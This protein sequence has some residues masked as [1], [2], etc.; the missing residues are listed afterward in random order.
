[1]RVAAVFG[2][3]Q[4]VSHG[5]GLFLFAA[6][7]PLMRE[8]IAITNW[9]LAAIGALTQLSYLAGALLLGFIG[10]KV[11]SARLVLTTGTI[12]TILLF[13]M[14]QLQDPIII[15]LVL[16][17]LAASAAI[18]WGAIVE[19]VGRNS[20]PEKC[21]TYLSFA[22]SGTAWGYGLNGLLILLVV[23]A[24]GWQSSWQIAALVGLIVVGLTWRLLTK[25]NSQSST[26]NIP[27]QA[28]IPASKLLTTII[29]ERTA[30][31]ACTVCFLV[32]FSTMPF[33]NWLN[34]YLHELQLPASVGGYTWTIVG[35]TGMVAGFIAGWIADRTSHG[36][37]LMIIFSGFALSLMAFV[38]DPS[39]F[40]AVAGFGYGLM[41]FPVWGILAGWLRQSFSSTATMQISSICMV[42]SGLG[43]ALGNLLAG[44]IRDT[45]GSLEL[46][47][48]I[49]TLAVLLMVFLTVITVGWKPVTKELVS[50]RS[51]VK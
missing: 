9:H 17:L 44:Y 14:S 36:T 32:G 41:Y 18:S 10:N 47:Y 51:M 26:H 40:A 24:L 29:R 1:M 19:I 25:L 12:T 30:L 20:K 15:T 3:N 5:F 27:E 11:S 48:C 45:T 21:S 2:L 42:T 8:S 50:P 22:A 31:F 34:T 46:V 39:Q 38:Y 23:P 35:V 6:L 33:A 49:V 16:V 28:M 43:G 13:S 7:V 37:A 4:I